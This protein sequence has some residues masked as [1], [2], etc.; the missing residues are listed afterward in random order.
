MAWRG[1]LNVLETS[2]HMS[3]LIRNIPLV[4]GTKTDPRSLTHTEGGRIPALLPLLR[5]LAIR[6][7]DVDI[8]L[9][10][11]LPALE[12]LGIRSCTL[13]H[14]FLH[15]VPN[16]ISIRAPRLRVIRVIS[17]RVVWDN[18]NW[19]EEMGALTRIRRVEFATYDF[20]EVHWTTFLAAHPTVEEL[21]MP[22]FGQLGA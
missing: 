7:I 3:L 12:D 13:P 20:H 18:I 9:V 2:G 6:Q 22:L 19:L 21:S 15:G 8:V 10:Q 14:R 5:T 16:I 1:L 17:L 4:R 11:A